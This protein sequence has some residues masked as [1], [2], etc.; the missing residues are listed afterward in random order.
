VAQ[1]GRGRPAWG[2]VAGPP[3]TGKTTFLRAL[4]KISQKLGIK[5]I[6]IQSKDCVE[7]TVEI[8]GAADLVVKRISSILQFTVS[9]GFRPSFDALSISGCSDLNC[10]I[11]FVNKKYK[12]DVAA[13][14]EP[15]LKMLMRFVNSDAVVI[16]TCLSEEYDELVRRLVVGM[17]YVLRSRITVPVVMDDIPSLVVNEVYGEAFSAMM[18]PYIFTKNKNLKSDEILLYNPVIT[19]PNSQG[20]FY[21]IAEPHKYVILFDNDRWALPRRDVEKIAYS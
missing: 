16:P 4:L 6:F 7:R 14:I 8:R 3:G 5:V 17:L 10:L 11:E 20:G 18:R 1:V 15:R 13:W 12:A 21:R 19:T 2:P 9:D